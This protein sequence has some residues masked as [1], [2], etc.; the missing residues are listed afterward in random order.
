[1]DEQLQDVPRKRRPK[2]KAAYEDYLRNH[3]P[4]L[5]RNLGAAQAWEPVF[6]DDVHGRV[7]SHWSPTY[8]PCSTL[9]SASHD[10]HLFPICR[11]LSPPSPN[12]MVGLHCLPAN[13]PPP[14][15]FAGSD[16][17]KQEIRLIYKQTVWGQRW[18]NFSNLKNLVG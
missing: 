14:S 10:L 18:Y 1:M 11:R 7:I 5:K 16:L 4:I 15:T 13:Q 9:C 8:F 3:H 12:A 2:L 6:Q 17:K